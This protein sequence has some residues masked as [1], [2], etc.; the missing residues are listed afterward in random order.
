MANVI[1]RGSVLGWATTRLFSGLSL[2]FGFP[3]L[4]AAHSVQGQ[5]AALYAASAVP[6]KFLCGNWA[7]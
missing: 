3:M 6:C 1:I 5:I 4:L 7:K 2:S